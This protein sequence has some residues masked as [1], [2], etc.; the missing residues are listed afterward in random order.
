MRCKKVSA[1]R[2][3][4][5]LED[6]GIWEQKESSRSEVRRIC[7][8][9]PNQIMCRPLVKSACDAKAENLYCD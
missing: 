7:L 1:D 3:R 5:P 4:D 9:P 8:S 2:E 6:L